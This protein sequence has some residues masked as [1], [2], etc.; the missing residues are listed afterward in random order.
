MLYDYSITALVTDNAANCVKAQEIVTS[1]FLN[2]IDLQYITHFFNLITKHIMEHNLVKQTIKGEELKT[3]SEIRWTS[4]YE[5]ASSVSHLRIALEHVLINNPDE[6]TNKIVKH[7]LRNSD[8][9]ANVNKLTKVLK[10]IKTTITLLES[11]RRGLKAEYWKIITD[12]AVQIHLNN[13][14]NQKS[15]NRLLAQICNYESNHNPYYEKFDSSLETIYETEI[16]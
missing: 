16:G 10:L 5:A 12:I 7:Y 11:A 9:F 14:G 1:Q 6:I 13:G 4:M 3:Y 15:R 2:I 8:F